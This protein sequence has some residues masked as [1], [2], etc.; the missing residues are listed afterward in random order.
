MYDEVSCNQRLRRIQK[1]VFIVFNENRALPK[2]EQQCKERK[3]KTVGIFNRINEL[4]AQFVSR[5]LRQEYAGL[6]TLVYHQLRDI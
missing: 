5:S 2:C 3:K 4:S 1:L 6:S